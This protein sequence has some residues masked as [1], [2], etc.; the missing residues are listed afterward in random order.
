MRRVGVRLPEG[1]VHRPPPAPVEMDLVPRVVE[2]PA[3]G[4]GIDDAV[5][6]AGGDAE[7]AGERR[8][9]VGVALALGAALA[10]HVDGAEGVDR[11]LVDVRVD[12]GEEP[13]DPPLGVALAVGDA[14]GERADLP[15]VARR[16]QG[17]RE[18]A[19]GLALRERL[20]SIPR[21]FANGWYVDRA[22]DAVVIQPGK[23][24]ASFSAHAIDEVV[25]DGA[26]EGVG[27]S[28]RRLASTGR[29]LQTGF[30]RT[31]ALFLFAGAV[32][33]LVY[34]GFRL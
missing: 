11:L 13:L 7:R 10:Q 26:V 28:V 9:Q 25:I 3:V 1:R 30:V 33:V 6:H 29:R 4:L 23:A 12:P 8:E 2:K 21:L 32:G 5:H 16:G 14:A 17:R 31:Y 15:E 34:L 24:A 19:P 27:G 20:G 18:V 22:Y